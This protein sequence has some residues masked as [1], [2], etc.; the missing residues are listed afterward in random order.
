M[1]YASKIEED[2][3]KRMKAEYKLELTAAETLLSSTEK[4]YEKTLGSMKRIVSNY[5]GKVNDYK[6]GTKF[7]VTEYH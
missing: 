2:Q 3:C 7:D 4:T 6:A 1:L 5:D